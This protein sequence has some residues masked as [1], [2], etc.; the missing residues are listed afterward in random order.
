MNQHQKAT[1]PFSSN[2]TSKMDGHR[3]VSMK[4]PVII[5]PPNNVGE[6]DDPSPLPG[7]VALEPG[8]KMKNENRSD[9]DDIKQQTHHWKKKKKDKGIDTKELPLSQ[10][11]IEQTSLVEPSPLKENKAS[12]AFKTKARQYKKNSNRCRR[13]HEDDFKDID[14]ESRVRTVVSTPVASADASMPTVVAH[15]VDEDEIDAE[16]EERVNAEIEQRIGQ[17]RERVRE[18]E[19][20]RIRKEAIR[21]R[22]MVADYE[23]R[24]LQR[25]VVM[26]EEEVDTQHGTFCNKSVYRRKRLLFYVLICVIVVVILTTIA[27]VITLGSTNNPSSGD[28]TDSS[29]PAESPPKLSMDCQEKCKDLLKGYPVTANGR[30][31]Q[32]A[33]LEHLQDPSSSPYGSV[34]N[35]W[36]VSRVS[37]F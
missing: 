8:N 12:H 24:D 28:N 30:E 16:I 4:L 23:E 3:R 34:I 37:L 35:C 36:D 9:S 25:G 20:E 33:I 31:F 13:F 32:N 1:T 17:E 26:Q 2:P 11:E 18:E 29:M 5:P 21:Q 27:V 19:R 15:L 22:N 7:A 6:P 14:C 10:V